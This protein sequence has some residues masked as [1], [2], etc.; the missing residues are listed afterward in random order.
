ME[1]SAGLGCPGNEGVSYTIPVDDFILGRLSLMNNKIR[2]RQQGLRAG[3]LSSLPP[4]VF[5][6]AIM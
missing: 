4:H 3:R 1:L 5:S 6:D 2:G